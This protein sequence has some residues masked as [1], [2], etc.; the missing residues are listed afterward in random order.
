MDHVTDI[1]IMEKEGSSG[2]GDESVN[3]LLMKGIAAAKG[4]DHQQAIM[5]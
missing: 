3:E 5:L 1:E 2:E 4:L